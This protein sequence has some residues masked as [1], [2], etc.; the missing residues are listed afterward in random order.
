M[1][2]SSPIRRFRR[3]TIWF[4]MNP[5]TIEGCIGKLI[6]SLLGDHEPV[7]GPQLGARQRF[8]LVEAIDNMHSPDSLGTHRLTARQTL[9]AM[10][11]AASISWPCWRG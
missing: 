3:R 9:P 10:I 8:K 7:T 6:D 1:G 5:L 11:Q 4:D 2:D